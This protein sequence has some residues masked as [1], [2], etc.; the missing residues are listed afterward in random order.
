MALEKERV[1]QHVLFLLRADW[2]AAGADVVPLSSSWTRSVEGDG[3]LRVFPVDV[4]TLK[5]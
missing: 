4:K 3:L 1:E 5:A 2:T